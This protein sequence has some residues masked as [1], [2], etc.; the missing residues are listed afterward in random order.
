M[1]G[2]LKNPS[3]MASPS[4]SPPAQTPADSGQ[5]LTQGS[6]LP[7]VWPCVLSI[8][9][10]SP[11]GQAPPAGPSAHSRGTGH[12]EDVCVLPGPS[13]LQRKLASGR[14]K[15]CAQLGHCPEY[16]GAGAAGRSGAV[17]K[18]NTPTW[19]NTA[20]A[21]LWGHTLHQLTGRVGAHAGDPMLS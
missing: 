17:W 16:P 11:R 3:L 10:T 7:G 5:V 20:A 19:A 14:A 12:R 6:V 1:E 18:A 21:R 4:P 13:L 8:K 9:G 2:P 15:T